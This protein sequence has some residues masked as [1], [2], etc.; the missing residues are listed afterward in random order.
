MRLIF[1]NMISSAIDQMKP[2][3]EIEFCDEHA[4]IGLEVIVT[5]Q[6]G[7]KQQGVVDGLKVQIAEKKKVR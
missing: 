1:K 7:S 3:K 5:L 4:I 2:F 6:D